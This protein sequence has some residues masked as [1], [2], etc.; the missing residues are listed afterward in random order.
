MLPFYRGAGYVFE[1]LIEKAIKNNFPTLTIL[2]EYQIQKTFGSYK[3]QNNNFNNVI[4]VNGVDLFCSDGS[5]FLT[6]QVK[7]VSSHPK[8]KSVRD[9]INTSFMIENKIDKPVSKMF[10]TTHLPFIPGIELCN[11]YGVQIIYHK[12]SDILINNLISIL[13]FGHPGFPLNVDADGDIEM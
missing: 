8:T 3:C 13:K 9:F 6:I 11:K 2:N 10:V 12:H 7:L 5:K 1:N 4:N